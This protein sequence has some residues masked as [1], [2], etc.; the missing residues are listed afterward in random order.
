MQIYINIDIYVWLYSGVWNV[1]D[2][3]WHGLPTWRPCFWPKLTLTRNH[4]I[5]EQFEVYHWPPLVYLFLTWHI[6]DTE[7]IWSGFEMYGILSGEIFSMSMYL[8]MSWLSNPLMLYL[9]FLAKHALNIWCLL[10]IHKCFKRSGHG[11]TQR[12]WFVKVSFAAAVGGG[13][14]PSQWV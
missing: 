11:F 9:F 7:N 3:L 5:T 14:N 6:I 4:N 10:M 1:W 2:P 13:I 12:V 8:C